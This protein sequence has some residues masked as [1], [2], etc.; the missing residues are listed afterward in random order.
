MMIVFFL[1][2]SIVVAGCF[3]FAWRTKNPFHF[4]ILVVS[5]CVCVGNFVLGHFCNKRCY[6]WPMERHIFLEPGKF[7]FDA[8]YDYD[9]VHI[10]ILLSENRTIFGTC[11]LV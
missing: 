5:V 11:L 3:Y 6:H 8:E 1:F 2:V 9:L 10:N 7:V 4:S